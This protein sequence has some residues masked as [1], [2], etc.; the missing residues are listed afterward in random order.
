MRGW[1]KALE[2]YREPRILAVLLLG[3]AS[4]LPLLLTYSTLTYWLAEAEVDKGWI[5]LFALAGLPYTWKFL[6]SPVI[7]R[8]PLPPFT[9]M[10]GRRRGWLLAVQ[11]LLLVGILLLGACDPRRDLTWMAALAVLVAFLSASQDIV[12]DAYRVELLSEREQGAGA[13]VIVIGY[14]IAMLVAGAGAL[15]IAEAAG[16]FMAYAVMASLLLVGVATTLLMPEPQVGA[17]APPSHAGAASWLKEAVAAPLIEFFS[18]NGAATALLILLFIM[19]YKVG[20]ALL[21]SMTGP[22]YVELGFSKTEVAAIVKLYGVLATLLGGFLGGLVVARRGLIQGLWICGLVQMASNL[23]F[24]LQAQAGHDVAMLTVTISIENLAGGMGTVA[25]VAY[26]AALCDVRF[27]ATQ[28]AL[29]SSFMAQARTTL[30][31]GGGF[32][33]ESM[34]WTGFFLLTTAAAV[35]GLLML[36]WLQRRLG[37]MT[38]GGTAAAASGQP[39]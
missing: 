28:Y 31:A 19:L 34:P 11:I 22:F 29:L 9:T 27:T 16:W 23:V 35:P 39:A 6:W 32:L 12:I 13:A 8:L 25:F 20:D 21:S 2:V 17:V 26:L 36:L 38:S 37:A 5:G 14:R 15:L 30:S 4:G 7:D 33:A 18:R 10:L 3:F 1:L 24:V